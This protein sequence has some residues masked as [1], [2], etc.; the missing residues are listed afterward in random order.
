MPPMTREFIGTNLRRARQALRLS[1]TTVANYL[2]LSRQAVSGAES[3]KR[4]ITVDELLKLSD[5][6]RV[7]LDFLIRPQPG[8][9]AEDLS[10]VQ[11]RANASGEKQLDEHDISEI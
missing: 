2:G 8:P 4:A 7:S 6:Y 1:Q 5:L 10:A 9:S 11:R 3:G